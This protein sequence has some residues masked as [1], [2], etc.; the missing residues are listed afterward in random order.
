MRGWDDRSMLQARILFLGSGGVRKKGEGEGRGR[1]KEGRR[2][3]G[4]REATTEAEGGGI[5]QEPGCC[6]SSSQPRQVSDRP[7]GGTS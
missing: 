6:A 5:Q 3:R 7:L 1:E 2:E 4:W